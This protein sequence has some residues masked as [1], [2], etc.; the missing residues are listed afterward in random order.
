MAVNPLRYAVM[1]QANKIESGADPTIMEI[2]PEEVSGEVTRN[3]MPEPA[4]FDVDSSQQSQSDGRETNPKPQQDNENKPKAGGGQFNSTSAGGKHYG[5]AGGQ[6]PSVG[7]NNKQ[8]YIDRS[9]RQSAR[10]KAME[11]SLNS[12]QGNVKRV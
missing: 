12:R 11:A 8:G 7:P 4:S 6:A 5:I 9:N 3:T 10:K 1:K 2:T